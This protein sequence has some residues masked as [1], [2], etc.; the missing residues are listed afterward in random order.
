MPV[1]ERCCVP[2]AEGGI[3]LPIFGDDE[4]RWPIPLRIVLY[5]IGLL[6]CFMGVGVICDTFMGAIEAVTSKKKRVPVPGTDRF[7]TVKVWNDTVSNLTLMAL[8]SSAPEI[9]L[10]VIELL[11]RGFYSGD[12][13]PSTIVG[14]AA[15]NLF[16]IIG[17]CISAIPDGE[18]RQINQTGVFGVTAVFSLWAYFWL[19]VIL[20]FNTPE[21]VDTTE[22]TLTFI[23]IFPLVCISYLVDIGYFSKSDPGEEGAPVC[24][25]RTPASELSKEELARMVNK[26]RRQSG[27]ALTDDQVMLSIERE[28][29]EPKSRAVYR[30]Q[31]LRAMMGGKRIKQAHNHDDEKT[32]TVRKA[33]GTSDDLDEV[34]AMRTDACVIEFAAPHYAI[35]ENCMEVRLLVLR[36]GALNEGVSVEFCTRQGT[37]HA[38]QDYGHVQ[39]KLQ[40]EPGE[41][42]HIVRVPIID[43]VVAEAE[44]EFYCDLSCAEIVPQPGSESVDTSKKSRTQVLL[45]CATTT[46][47]IID[48]D[49]PG[50]LAFESETHHVK[51]S[52]EDC[53]V[54]VRVVRKTGTTGKIACNYRTENGTALAPLD[55]ESL[56]GT[57]EFEHGQTSASIELK[58]KG[59][60]RYDNSEMFRLIL[61]DPS[62]GAKFDADM[63]GG[64][65][66]AILTVFIEPDEFAKNAVDKMFKLLNRNWTKAHIGHSNW[67]DQ[68]HEA[69]HVNGGDEDADPPTCLDYATHIF[70]LPWK[71]VFAFCPPTDYAGGWV[72]FFMALMFIGCVTALVGDMAKL[73]GCCMG[74]PD[75][76]TAITFVALGTSL[77]DT[78]ASKTAAV[79]DPYADASVVNVTGSNSV[80][81]FLGLG[82]PWMMGSIYWSVSGVD[83]T[84]R[85]KYAEVLT[86]YPEYSSGAFIV[87]SGDLGFAVI[88]FTSIALLT[89]TLLVI[90][91]RV[92]GAELGGD[93]KTANASSAVL[94]CFW[95]T[96][97]ALCSWNGMKNQ[98]NK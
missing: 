70:C 5:L 97:V 90:R 28:T 3:L 24:K 14:S 20:V 17:V 37:A 51:E 71:I 67:K 29:A 68:F 26:V 69:F 96:Y 56:E 53:S 19:I 8:G 34:Q 36:R 12:L 1:E 11:G 75:S 72:C 94:F 38:G 18:V 44:E 66:N 50:V 10:S 85:T 21:V 35:L 98:Q 27:I 31:A 63:D 46:I 59:K 81:V 40:F 6:W 64:E 32:S 15:F 39:G 47:T 13:G 62:G 93:K 48:D 77:P 2:G 23:F 78:F 74:V 92:C 82:L 58:I 30:T 55:F 57:L 88:V 42:E 22:A 16:C 25:K 7:M 84:W 33:N 65:E 49:Y 83:D 4:Q 86:Q 41:T 87:R 91:R 43:D 45:G 76:I 9:L 60:G 95:L 80:N 89:L 61:E 79:Q 52:V 73:L 54:T